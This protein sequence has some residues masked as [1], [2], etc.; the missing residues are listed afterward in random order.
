M[1]QIQFVYKDA[2][3]F[4]EELRKLCQWHKSD[5]YSRVYFQI[6]SGTLD[7]DM[8]SYLCRKIEETIPA[9][10]YA[11]CSS[12]GNIVEGNFSAAE[13]AISCT[14]FEYPT[15]QIELLQ[16]TL[17]A[18]S[19]A[20]VARELVREVE[21]RPWVKAVELLTTIRD[22][23]MTAL[24]DGISELREDVAVFGGGALCGDISSTEACVF[25]KAGGYQK[26]GIVFILLGGEDFHVDTNFIT[27][28]KPLGGYLNVT[29]ADGC[30]LKELNHRPA[31]ETY[32]KYLHIENDKDFFVN[33]LEF[34]FFYH[35]HGIDIMRAPV[36]SNADGSL[37]MTSDMGENVKARLAYGDPW[38]ILDVTQEEGNR[39]LKFAPDCIFV[40]SCAGRRTFWGDREVGKETEPYQMVAPT[41][42]FYTMGEF[43]R[44]GKYLNQ[45]NVTQVL[46]AMR[47]GEPRSHPEKPALKPSREFRG[48]ISII[49]RMATFV[50]TTTEELEELNRQLTAMAVTDGLTGLYNRT[51]IQRQITKAI[52]EDRQ[53][54]VYLIMMD[55]DYF[56]KVNNLYGH[57]AGD[58][59]LKGTA[60]VIKPEAGILRPGDTA[61]RWGGEEFMMLLHAGDPAEVRDMAETIRKSISKLVFEGV[62]S[63]TASLGAIRV[64]KGEQADKA[65]MRADEALYEAKGSGRNR[66]VFYGE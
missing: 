15:T 35:L 38:T 46:A 16:Y 20:E 65:C 44:T 17:T 31:Y 54:D 42:G 24:C 25:S 66:V 51:E 10:L 18:E 36:T 14:F 5:L 45:H 2:E 56:K 1:K 52:D 60:G 8:I 21:A 43:L 39:L 59:V 28:W 50:K 22:K 4:E 12:F 63:V 32:Y 30:I 40:F 41:S 61:G 57:K 58:D 33:T 6:F 37:V 23:S 34:P 29:S 27:G 64:R 9:A 62:G 53:E 19:Q 55:L 13:I 48:R 47:E 3:G 26:N 7:R 11:G 49:N